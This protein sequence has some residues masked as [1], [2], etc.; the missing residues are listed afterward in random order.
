MLLTRI[1]TTLLT[2]FH[3]FI[4]NLFNCGH[5]EGWVKPGNSLFTLRTFLYLEIKRTN[6]QI[7]QDFKKASNC[8]KEAI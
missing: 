1:L 2:P 7:L 5:V 6:N 4:N 3:S 8:S